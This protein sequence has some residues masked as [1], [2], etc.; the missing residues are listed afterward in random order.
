MNKGGSHPYMAT[1]ALEPGS[2]QSTQ[3]SVVLSRW[4]S[5]DVDF[6]NLIR[7]GRRIDLSALEPGTFLELQPCPPSCNDQSDKPTLHGAE[8][9]LVLCLDGFSGTLAIENGEQWIR[10]LTSVPLDRD[11]EAAE[12]AWMLS[13][14]A[15][16][17]PPPLLDL[18]TTI[19]PSQPIANSSGSRRACLTLRT[20]D[21]VL[22]T[23]GYATNELWQRLFGESAKWSGP[24]K[25]WLDWRSMVCKS[26]VVVGYHALSQ[27]LVKKLSV[28]DI[29]LP[30]RVFFDVYGRGV[31]QVGTWQL[32]VQT[33]E[34]S[35]LEVLAMYSN[36]DN[37]EI[38]EMDQDSFEIGGTRVQRE[39]HDS[40]DLS[41]VPIQLQ[42]E[43]GVLSMQL[44]QMQ[45]LAAGSVIRLQAPA[46][47][48]SVKILA[49]GQ[50][51]GK[52]DLIDVDGQLGVQIT[53]W[54]SE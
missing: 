20:A 18:F 32:N 33:T 5:E 4:C 48:P 2:R 43:L 9:K 26:Q 28:G 52:G 42:F 54:A 49:G 29:V 12:R 14:A 23:Y 47:P 3:S 39:T 45:T 51:I 34:G 25:S 17:L 40:A 35:E 21:H 30:E 22:T 15:A 50:I 38:T 24:R 13:T 7:A 27:S 53:S 1:K 19:R 8:E 16:L 41:S 44:G 10:A 36:S 6:N 46:A 31:V 11:T 37:P